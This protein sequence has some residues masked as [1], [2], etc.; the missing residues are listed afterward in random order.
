MLGIRTLVDIGFFLSIIGF[1]VYPFVNEAIRQDS[2][3]NKTHSSRP[4]GEELFEVD[5]VDPNDPNQAQGKA[6]EIPSLTIDAI[7]REV[8]ALYLDDT[9]I[10]PGNLTLEVR[11]RG[12][13][14]LCV[15]GN[16]EAAH[17][18]IMD[19]KHLCKLGGVTS[20]ADTRDPT[21]PVLTD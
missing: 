5:I 4:A 8:R 20:F 6:P 19:A 3:P 10:A 11:R 14:R 12:I 18:V 16:P 2:T 15:K 7:G 9:K 21:R 13:R 1:V 17:Q